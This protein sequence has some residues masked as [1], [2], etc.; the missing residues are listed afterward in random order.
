MYVCSVSASPHPPTCVLSTGGCD[1][2]T[3]PTEIKR[4]EPPC[5]TIPFSYC[6][7]TNSC[8]CQNGYRPLT[9]D[10]GRLVECEFIVMVFNRSRGSDADNAALY[11]PSE[12]ATTGIRPL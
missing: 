2:R 3:R 7:D 4:C 6:Q 12:S 10:Q 11:I 8:R 5:S 1:E 9:N